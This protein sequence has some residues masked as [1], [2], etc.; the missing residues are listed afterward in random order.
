MGTWVWWVQNFHGSGSDGEIRD[1]D[2]WAGPLF[3]HCPRGCQWLSA[4]QWPCL[5]LLLRPWLPSHCCDTADQEPTLTPSHPSYSPALHGSHLPFTAGSA[6]TPSTLPASPGRPGSPRTKRG[7]GCQVIDGFNH[8][9]SL[10]PA[11]LPYTVP[12]PCR[13]QSKPHQPTGYSQKGGDHPP[14]KLRTL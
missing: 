13:G 1:R 4:S 5:I 11:H 3:G 12:G 6:P 7:Q 10:P 9:P 2:P 8:E 14:R